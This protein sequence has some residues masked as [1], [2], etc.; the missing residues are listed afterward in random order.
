MQG[1]EAAPSFYFKPNSRDGTDCVPGADAKWA[2]LAADFCDN[3]RQTCDQ[4]AW[5]ESAATVETM[6]RL[7][8]DIRILSRADRR[9]VSCGKA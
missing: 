2:R 3:F 5:Y 4:R 8:H 9:K 7:A 1:T 6:H